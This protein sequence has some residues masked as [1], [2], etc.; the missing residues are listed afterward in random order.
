MVAALG[1]PADLLDR[2]VDYLP[3]APVIRDIGAPRGG[4]VAAIDARA[5]GEAVID[6]GGGRR[7]A[8][9]E[10]DYAVGFDQIAGLGAAVEAGDPLARVHA[11]NENE[12]DQ[13]IAAV[14][15]C[16]AI[17]DAISDDRALI[18]GRIG[19]EDGA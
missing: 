8:T 16:Y 7:Q 15:A 5:L 14:R 13:A 4:F 1:G 10:L 11:R 9:D 19:P 18:A 6:L 17:G 12:A 3:A 2:W